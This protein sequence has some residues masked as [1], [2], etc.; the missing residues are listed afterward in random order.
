MGG[1]EFRWDDTEG[2]SGIDEVTNVS[3]VVPGVDELG[4]GGGVIG[5][6]HRQ[7]PHSFP[8]QLQGGGW[9]FRA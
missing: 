1:K 2:S 9:H 4:P 5:E 3:G 8:C 6:M 7:G